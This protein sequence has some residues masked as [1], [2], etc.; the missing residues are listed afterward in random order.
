MGQEKCK[1]Q[2]FIKSCFFLQKA[3]VL[4]EHRSLYLFILGQ[5]YDLRGQGLQRL[6]KLQVPLKHGVLSFHN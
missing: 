3:Y 2:D 4:G 1:K 6:L 5:I